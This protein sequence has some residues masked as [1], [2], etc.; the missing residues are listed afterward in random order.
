[1]SNKVTMKEQRKTARTE[2]KIGGEM[3]SLFDRR[4]NEALF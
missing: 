1:M 4:Q 3:V 2:E